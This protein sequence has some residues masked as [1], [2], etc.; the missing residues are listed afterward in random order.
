MAKTRKLRG[1]SRKRAAGSK[2]K[3]GG[4]LLG[5][6]VGAL[7]TALPSIVLYEALR[8]QGKRAKNSVKKMMKGGKKSRK[9]HKKRVH[10]KRV[11]SK[12]HKKSR[13]THKK[14]MHKKRVH[15]KRVVSKSRKTRKVRRSRR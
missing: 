6:V 4:S 13:K 8:V 11:V 10:K 12:S 7:K 5:S 1:S 9:S 2:N 3:K 15:K 14:S